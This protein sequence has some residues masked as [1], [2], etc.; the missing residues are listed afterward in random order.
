LS[1]KLTSRIS[2]FQNLFHYTGKEEARVLGV[3]VFTIAQENR[4]AA[5]NWKEEDTNRQAHIKLIGYA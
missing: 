2:L 5:P 3:Y 1:L 4:S